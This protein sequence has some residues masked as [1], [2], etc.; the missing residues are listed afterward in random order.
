MPLA[1]LVIGRD[2]FLVAGAFF[3]RFRSCNYTWPGWQEFFRTTETGSAAA[4]GSSDEQ[5]HSGCTTT[6]KASPIQETKSG[7]TSRSSSPKAAPYVQ[8]LYIS[9]MNTVAQILLIAS[10]I[11]AYPLQWPPQEVVFGLGGLTGVLTIASG[12]AYLQKHRD[13]DKD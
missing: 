8:P 4:E 6:D 11:T 13:E 1:V 10:C 7:R 9:K 12:Y 2:V 3:L 5:P